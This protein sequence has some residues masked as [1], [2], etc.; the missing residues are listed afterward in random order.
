M[1]TYAVLN[2]AAI[3]FSLWVMATPLPGFLDVSARLGGMIGVYAT[4]KKIVES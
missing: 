4:L 2:L 1:F 3:F